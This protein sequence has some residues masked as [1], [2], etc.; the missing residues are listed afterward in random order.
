M[1][2]S[3]WRVTHSSAPRSQPVQVMSGQ[4]HACRAECPHSAFF[5]HSRA[6]S[7]ILRQWNELYLSLCLMTNKLPFF[8]QLCSTLGALRGLFLGEDLV[9]MMLPIWSPE[10]PQ[11]GKIGPSEDR[12]SFAAEFCTTLIKLTQFKHKL[13]EYLTQHIFYQFQ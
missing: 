5:C 7:T 4:S 13:G 6:A 2:L 12:K 1:H 9:W 10:K 8:Y 11:Q 3:G